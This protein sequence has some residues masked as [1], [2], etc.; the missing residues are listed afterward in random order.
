MSNKSFLSRSFLR[1]RSSEAA[2][3]VVGRQYRQ[4]PLQRESVEAR[5]RGTGLSEYCYLPEDGGDEKNDDD[6]CVLHIV[7]ASLISPGVSV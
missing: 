5:G 1:L 6:D 4:P 3:S 7:P 2:E